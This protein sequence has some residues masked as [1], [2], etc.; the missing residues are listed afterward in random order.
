MILYNYLILYASNINFSYSLPK[1]CWCSPKEFLCSVS[2]FFIKVNVLED[3]Y[4][5]KYSSRHALV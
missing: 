4:Y 5:S 3:Q 1:L 2:S